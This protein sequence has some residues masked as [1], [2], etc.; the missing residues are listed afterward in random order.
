MAVLLA[1]P[2]VA[3][4]Q[5]PDSTPGPGL[6]VV[7]WTTESEVNLAGF[8]IYRGESPDGPY[9]KINDALIPASP[10][11]LTGGSYSY[12]DTTA[13]PGMTYYYMLE[14]VELDGQATTHGP[15]QVVARGQGIS[16]GVQVLAA[17][18][19]LATMALGVVVFM[20]RRR[21]R[22]LAGHQAGDVRREGEP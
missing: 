17:A 16:V 4:A 7:E 9:L 8:N 18:A 12:T 19:L 14:D 20:I 2:A 6:V 5:Q 13:E 10:D 22:V 21:R 15:V 3:R 11:P 1:G